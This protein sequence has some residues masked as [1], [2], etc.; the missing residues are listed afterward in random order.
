MPTITRH[1][2]GCPGPMEGEQV[3]KGGKMQMKLVR[4][5]VV[6]QMKIAS[7]RGGKVNIEVFS[8]D[9]VKIEIDRLG[10]MLR[11]MQP[12][13]GTLAV[14]PL[15]ARSEPRSDRARPRGPGSA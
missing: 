7:C 11:T 2:Q 12:D 3:A 5:G 6:R 13:A 15:P 9:R 10:A 4:G 1:S 14:A 8:G